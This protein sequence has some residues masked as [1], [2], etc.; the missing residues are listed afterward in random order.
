MLMQTKQ[1]QEEKKKKKVENGQKKDSLNRL[2]IL[3][4]YT[5]ALCH[6]QMNI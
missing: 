1:Y 4:K 3:I 6:C 2:W 5:K